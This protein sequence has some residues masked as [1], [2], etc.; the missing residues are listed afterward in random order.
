MKILIYNELS[1]L[2]ILINN[3]KLENKER[4]LR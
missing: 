3:E 4:A 2:K 1:F